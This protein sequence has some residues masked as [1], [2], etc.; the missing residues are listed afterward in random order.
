MKQSYLKYFLYLCLAT[1]FIAGNSNET[2][3]KPEAHESFLRDKVIS[4]EPRALILKDMEK[5]EGTCVE[6][7]GMFYESCR[8]AG[9]AV[10]C[11]SRVIKR[12]CL[13]DK[14]PNYKIVP[15]RITYI[16]KECAVCGETKLLKEFDKGKTNKDGIKPECKKC[17]KKY[18]EEQR[19]NNPYHAKIYYQDNKEEKSKYEK[20]YKSRPEVKSR[21]NR[22]AK[23]RRET[24]IAFKVSGNMSNHIRI[25]LN[26]LKHG[27]HWETLVDYDLEKLMVHLESLFTE[28]MSWKNYGYGKYKWNIDHIIARSKFNITSN[29]CQAFKNCWSLDNLQPLW[30]VRNMEKG[31]KPM[32][33]KYLIK[34]F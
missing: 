3:L 9:R 5:R 33:P 23:E 4:H 11:D 14:F 29:T 6:I 10:K 1:N 27:A 21:L 2:F 19:E 30:Q 22:Q 25:S 28:G 13:S 20:E 26:S 16:K 17:R 32:E 31:D 7:D 12:R 18:Q 24:D 34:P 15:Y 8:S